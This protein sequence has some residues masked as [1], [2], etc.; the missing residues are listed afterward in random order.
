MWR[1]PLFVHCTVFTL[2]AVT[3]D[4]NL[5]GLNI[6]HSSSHDSGGQ[7]SEL[8]VAARLQSPW[9]GG[10]AP[11]LLLLLVTTEGISQL[12]TTSFQSLPSSSRHLLLCMLT[13]PLRLSYDGTWGSFLGP[14]RII[15]DDYLVSESL[16]SPHPHRFYHIK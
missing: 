4:H 1:D 14:T 10:F 13:L 6:K 15:Q 11:S 16:K 12:V 2:A 5:R 3:N 8:K 7:K 9:K